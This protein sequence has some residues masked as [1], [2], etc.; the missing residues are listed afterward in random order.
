MILI[1]GIFAICAGYAK[2]DSLANGYSFIGSIIIFAIITL[3]AI[4]AESMA[5]K[6]IGNFEDATY[7]VND[8]NAVYGDCIDDQ[9]KV[10]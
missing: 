5:G 3:F 2:F 7:A 10:D 1:F 9:S 4:L 6:L 8:L